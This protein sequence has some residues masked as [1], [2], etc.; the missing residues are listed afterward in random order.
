MGIVNVTPDSFSDGGNYFNSNDAVAHALE[1]INDGADIIDLGAQSTRPN[2]VEIS[3]EDEWKR[4]QPV[5]VELRKQTDVPISVDTYFPYVAEN[6]VKNG[7]DIINDISGV[8]NQEMAKI[9]KNTRCGW[10]LMHNGSGA[11]PEIKTFFAEI[12]KKCSDFGIDKSQLCLDMGIGFGKDY[13]QCLQLLA[14]VNEYLVDGYPMLLGTSRKRVIGQGSKQEIAKNRVYG[15]IS[16]DTV[17]IL[18][19]ANIIRL[20]D[21][22]NEIQG[23]YM[24][25]ELK[26]AGA[27]IG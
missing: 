1:L 20:H 23:I 19:G 24:A 5:L 6:A 27:K 10:I 7:A 18:A 14:R 25:D 12:L 15:N 8:F 16:A 17:A 21:V 3:P 26:R 4:L 2:Y 22:K 13:E 11:V 9:V